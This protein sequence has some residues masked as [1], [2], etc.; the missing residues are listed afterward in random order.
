MNLSVSLTRKWETR[1]HHQFVNHSTLTDTQSHQFIHQS[2]VTGRYLSNELLYLYHNPFLAQ[3]IFNSVFTS[4][5]VTISF[6]SLH[7]SCFLSP[8]V[9]PPAPPVHYSVVCRLSFVFCSLLNV[10]ANHPLLGP[11]QFIHPPPLMT[12]A[13]W[14]CLL[15]QHFLTCSL[16][17]R[18]II[19]PFS[20]SVINRSVWSISGIC[21][22]FAITKIGVIKC[23]LSQTI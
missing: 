22:I 4:I 16:F 12:P 15:L 3:F 13:A 21:V 5:P 9:L 10:V 23:D 14:S 1:V 17:F 7:A 8:F 2:T 11:D 6:I 18:G 19:Y 20:L